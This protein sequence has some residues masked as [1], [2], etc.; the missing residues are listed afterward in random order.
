MRDRPDHDPMWD[1]WDRMKRDVDRGE[2]DRFWQ[3]VLPL[4]EPD[5]VYHCDADDCPGLPWEAGPTLDRPSLH[6]S[7]AMRARKVEGSRGSP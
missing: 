2:R 3:R 7:C 5:R 6:V 1:T 4:P